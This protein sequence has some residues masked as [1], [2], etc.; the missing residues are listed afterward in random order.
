VRAWHAANADV[1]G[2]ALTIAEA[3]KLGTAI[4]GDLMDEGR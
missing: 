3:F 1:A 2:A 4:F